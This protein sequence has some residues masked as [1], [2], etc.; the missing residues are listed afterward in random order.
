M[1]IKVSGEK[2]KQSGISHLVFLLLFALLAAGMITGY[3]DILPHFSRSE[4][5]SLV[6]SLLNPTTSQSWMSVLFPFATVKNEAFFNT[7]VSMRN[8]YFS[9]TLLLFFL[10][11]L[12]S[13]KNK[14]QNFL[15]FTGLFFLLLSTGGIF[16][17]IAYKFIPFIGY[18]RLNGEFRIF[19]IFCFM[20]IAAIELDKFIQE[21]KPFYGTIKWIYYG[22]EI[23]VIAAIAFGIYE[24]VHTKQS[25]F[26]NTNI[27]SAQQGLSSKLKALIDN[28][29]FYDTLWVQGFIQLFFLW[30]IKWAM[31]LRL[32]SLLKKMV[33]A[34]VIIACLLN[35]PFTGAGKAS[36]ATIQQV[37]N[38]SP[39][40][41]TT[42]TLIPINQYDTVSDDEERMIGDWSM[43]NKQ[44]GSVS[45]VFYPIILKSTELYFESNIQ[46]SNK[47]FLFT[48]DTT[49]N[50][51]IQTFS[52]QKI[53][54]TI[55]NATRGNL[56]LQQNI[57]PNWYYIHGKEK[58]EVQPFGA[59]FMSA[60]ISKE[61]NK[62]S[63][64]FDPTKV[65]AA[66]IVSLV[67]FIILLLLL[68]IL[69]NKPTLSFPSSPQ[70]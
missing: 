14:L 12:L 2:L 63:F 31:G 38:K 50:I 54:V 29:S 53:D 43:Y 42:P 26:Y 30:V 62:T 9:L 58:K 48:D 46:Y 64:V 27:L 18:I 20:L 17:T 32:W 11:S 34:D 47:A 70:Q 67:I 25:I 56:I 35:V 6:D 60:P 5:V 49:A 33:V 44:P 65:K 23:I 10:L 36:V 13:K 24:S 19:S 1:Q 4:K 40:G 16:K 61:N 68:L 21:K 28:I 57:Y 39:K 66:M 7:D 45:A 37:I 8:S 52:P 22:V 59:S 51:S 41:I 55:N 3:L 69:Q 15:L